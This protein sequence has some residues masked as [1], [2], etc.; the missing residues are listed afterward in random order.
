M[1]ILWLLLGVIV[2]F[3][4]AATAALL[5]ILALVGLGWL[6]LAWL[7]LLLV[8]T[9][10]GPVAWLL[11]NLADSFLLLARDAQTIDAECVNSRLRCVGG[12]TGLARGMLL[13]LLLLHLCQRLL[14]IDGSV[15]GSEPRHDLQ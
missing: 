4:T 13:R 9:I 7:A 14:R 15:Q 2:A 10:R 3:A 12:A 11:A 1:S 5:A 8:G 6:A